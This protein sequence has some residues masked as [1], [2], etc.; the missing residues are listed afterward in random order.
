[1]FALNGECAG[2]R[3]DAATDGET[4]AGEK[5]HAKVTQLAWI[6]NPLLQGLD[7]PTPPV[8]LCLAIL[9]QA[10]DAGGGKAQGTMPTP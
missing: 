4:E 1:M 5:G 6:P 9:P 2:T 10:Q 7:L 3:V 8:T